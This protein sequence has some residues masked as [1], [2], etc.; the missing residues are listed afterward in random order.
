MK[1]FLAVFTGTAEA[2]EAS[3][4]NALSDAE[5]DERTQAGVKAW[6]TW[7]EEHE[8]HVSVPG[9]PIGKT[10]RVSTGGIE[11]AQNNLCGYVVVSA[12]SHAAAAKLFESHPH[13]SIFPGEA[14]EVME[15]LPVPVPGA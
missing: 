10:L 11:N 15:C 9:G 8:S 1:N 2:M 4:W 13:F 14:V 5:R 7:M 3:G 12:D 6:Q